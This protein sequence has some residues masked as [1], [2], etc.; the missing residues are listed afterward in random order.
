M[1]WTGP[2]LLQLTAKNGMPNVPCIVNE[3][4]F[5]KYCLTQFYNRI[6]FV[7]ILFFFCL[8]TSAQLLLEAPD[9]V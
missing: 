1:C 7:F 5:S 2:R 8:I 3:V 4:P 6:L 9:P